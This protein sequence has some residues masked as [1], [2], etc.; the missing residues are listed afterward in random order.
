MII[1]TLK[2]QLLRKSGTDGYGQPTFENV[3]T[4]M[5]AP[6]RSNFGSTHTTVRTDSAGSKG[7]AQ[8]DKADVVFLA[9]PWSKVAIG[10]KVIYLGNML[11]VD[12]VHPRFD[13]TGRL[14]HKQVT[15]SALVDD[16]PWET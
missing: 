15:C 5:V 6:V 14:D 9:V 16:R 8:E 11:K 2:L 10:D 7:H 13:V 3:G 1:P 12:F 4:E